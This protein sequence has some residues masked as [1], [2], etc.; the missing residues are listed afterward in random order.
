MLEPIAK[1]IKQIAI[2]AYEHHQVPSYVIC[3][4]VQFPNWRRRPYSVAD[5]IVISS[6]GSISFYANKGK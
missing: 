4:P 6:D 2:C 5:I 1:I 3:P